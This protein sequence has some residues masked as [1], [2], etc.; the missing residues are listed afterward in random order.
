MSNAT[1]I[2]ERPI[3][4]SGE[5]VRALLAGKKTQTRRV[6]KPQPFEDNPGLVVGEYYPTVIAR[7]GS[8]EPGDPVWGVWNYDGDY[9]ARCPFGRPG[10]R[11][12]I[13]ESMHED[14]SE[15]YYDA[16]DSVVELDEDSPHVDQMLSWAHHAKRSNCASIH[17]PRWASRLT[18]ELTDVR[19]ERAQE[20]TNKDAEAEGFVGEPMEHID[21]WPIP[22]RAQFVRLW[23]DLNR[24]R[25]HAFHW[26]ANPWVWVLTFS[27]VPA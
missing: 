5:M 20:I 12:W 26:N 4:F 25:N 17:M 24:H 8:E 11:L 21:D 2:R 14:G 22:P 9:A 16:D 13:R 15:W 23:D 3:L 10:D 1:A 27:V 7:D 6:V 18:L 19:V